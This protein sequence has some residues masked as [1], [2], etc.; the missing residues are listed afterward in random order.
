[1]VLVRVRVSGINK[2]PCLSW[3]IPSLIRNHTSEYYSN[4]SLFASGIP[5]I[6]E[7]CTRSSYVLQPTIGWAEKQYGTALLIL[8]PLGGVGM[9]QHFAAQQTGDWPQPQA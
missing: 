1:M 2:N 7:S 6:L 8:P 5:F 3:V 9:N 4:R